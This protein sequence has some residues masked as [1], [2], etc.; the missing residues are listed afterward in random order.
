MKT[1]KKWA[2]MIFWGWQLVSIVILL[3][4]LDELVAV[5]H[6]TVKALS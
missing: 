1:L 4:H 3:T 2:L 6:A 5:F